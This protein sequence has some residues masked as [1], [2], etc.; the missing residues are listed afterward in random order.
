MSLEPFDDEGDTMTLQDQ[1]NAI[2]QAAKAAASEL[3]LATSE[4]KND[5]IRAA[6]A[7]IRAAAKFISSGKPARYGSG[8]GRR[9]FQCKA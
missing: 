3:A 8:P 6:A 9:A 4:Q 2:G 1:M 7:E 5:A